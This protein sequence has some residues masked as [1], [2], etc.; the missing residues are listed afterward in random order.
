MYLPNGEPKKENCASVC[1]KNECD[2]GK[3]VSHVVS[4]IAKR[5][6]YRALKVFQWLFEIAVVHNGHAQPV[7]ARTFYVH[8]YPTYCIKC[9]THTRNATSVRSHRHIHITKRFPLGTRLFSCH[10]N[11]YRKRA[12]KREKWQPFIIF[13][14]KDEK[15]FSESNKRSCKK[16]CPKL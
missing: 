11:R 12:S 8:L 3:G 4:I 2:S 1:H 9:I 10:K 14:Q 7:N 5:I 16:Y 15:K 13:K 6:W